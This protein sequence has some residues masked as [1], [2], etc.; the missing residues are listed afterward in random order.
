[1]KY[2]PTTY[3]ILEETKRDLAHVGFNVGLGPGDD[4]SNST[5]MIG[6]RNDFRVVDEDSSDLAGGL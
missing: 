4:S 2:D 3:M 1:M 6:H 5:W